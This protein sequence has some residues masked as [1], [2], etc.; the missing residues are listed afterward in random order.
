M[1]MEKALSSCENIGIDIYW[2]R[3]PSDVEYADEVMLLTECPIK[4]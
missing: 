3:N 4:L 2:D 1:V